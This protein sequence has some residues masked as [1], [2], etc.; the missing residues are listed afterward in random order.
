M[1]LSSSIRR[2]FWLLLA[3]AVGFG[4]CAV[5]AQDNTSKV[6]SRIVS[7]REKAIRKELKSAP[8]DDWS[9]GYYYGDGLGVN[10]TLVYAPESGFVFTW[11]GCLGLYDQNY[12]DVRLDG[13]RLRLVPRLPNYPSKG[14]QGISEDFYRVRWGARHYLISSDEMVR[15]TNAV[16]AGFEPRK[17]PHGRFL[18]KD[19]DEKKEVSGPPP[20][21]VEYTDYILRTP[22]DAHIVS[23]GKSRSN[24][25]FVVHTVVLNVGRV[26]GVRKGMEFFVIGCN[27]GDATVLKVD[28]HSS[29]AELSV[30]QSDEKPSPGQKLSTRVRD[31]S[32]S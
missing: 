20:I 13:G 32:G 1:S 18:L 24:D 17:Y 29:E 15:F 11:H 21:P 26:E 23:V 12:G 9:G 22:L 31:E 30:F 7:G 6:H 16:N 10:V 2:R 4:V 28:D 14:F 27:Y 5:E 25:P 8:A 19:G 3:A